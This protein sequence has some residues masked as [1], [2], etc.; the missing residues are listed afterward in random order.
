MWPAMALH[1]VR[2][3]PDHMMPGMVLE[4]LRRVSGYLADQTRPDGTLVCARHRV[5]HTAKNAR[6][7][8][9][10]CALFQQTG[11]PRYLERARQ[12]ARRT[13]ARL[14]QDPQHGAWIYLP[15][16]HDVRNIS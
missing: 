10:D 16:R 14:A 7:I 12:R 8:V 5:E 6:S 3:E 9:V 15:A 11:D 13:V 1:A 2:A 4:V